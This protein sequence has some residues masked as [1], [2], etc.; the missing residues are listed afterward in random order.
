LISIPPEATSVHERLIRQKGFVRGLYWHYYTQYEAAVKRA[1]P[2][3]LVLE[4]GSGAGFYREIRRE[5]VFLDVRRGANVDIVGS[6]LALPVRSESVS[7][8]LMLNVLHHLQEPVVFLHECER[9]LKRG[10]RVCLIERTSAHSAG[11]S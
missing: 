4:I 3:G 8:V 11:D 5:A 1:I 10:G 2:G 9:V 6:A 7:A